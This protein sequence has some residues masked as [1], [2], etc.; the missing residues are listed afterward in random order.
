V[1]DVSFAEDNKTIVSASLDK[2]VKMWNIQTGENLLNHN[3]GVEVW[4]LDVTSNAGTIILGCADG[5]VRMLTESGAERG[6]G[7]KGGK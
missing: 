5:S 2:T 3:A 1:Q 7:T 6:R 4:S